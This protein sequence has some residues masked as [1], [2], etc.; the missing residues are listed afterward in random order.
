[1]ARRLTRRAGA[2]AFFASDRF[3]GVETVALWILVVDDVFSTGMTAAV[4]VAKLRPFLFEPVFTL[5]CPLKLLH[6]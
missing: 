2:E 1:M 5:A 6:G 3:N 4:V